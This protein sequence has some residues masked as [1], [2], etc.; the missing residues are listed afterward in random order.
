MFVAIVTR[1][2][3]MY[4]VSMLSKFLNNHTSDHWRAVKRVF[5]Y[6][7]GTI[8]LGIVYS[9]SEN[10]C[11]IVGYSDADYASDLET[12]RSTT[13]YV[14][15]MAG[16]PVTWSSQR[17]R[18][19]TLSTTESEYVAAASAAKELCWIRKL[20]SG[21]GCGC[22]SGSVLFVDNQSAI[23]LAK[24]PE[25]HK[26]TKNIDIRYHYIREQCA[27]GEIEIK[28]VASEY[29]KADILTEALPRDRFMR[30]R[31]SLGLIFDPNY[32]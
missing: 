7:V 13:G 25:Y 20:L 27:T 6:L 16:G 3:I 31:D 22:A 1:L 4:A 9:R 21:I 23:R 24:N 12:R 28:Y 29:Q 32:M 5:A 2:D 18:L 15:C 10:E 19:V 17:Q 14:F 26:R 8:D 11:N 30:L